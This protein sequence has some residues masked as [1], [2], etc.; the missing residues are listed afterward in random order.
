MADKRK[1]AVVFV[2]SW[3][4]DYQAAM[5][6]HGEK[7]EEEGLRVFYRNPA[8]YVA[9]DDLYPGAHL[10]VVP[11]AKLYPS[12]KAIAAD[13]RKAK[14]KVDVFSPPKKAGNRNNAGGEE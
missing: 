13:Y 8:N 3:P 14:V 10:C 2:A 12:A 9:K 4:S 6:R 5:Q 11:D 1:L 7:L